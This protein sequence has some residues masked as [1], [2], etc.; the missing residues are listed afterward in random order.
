MEVAERDLGFGHPLCR[1]FLVP[2]RRLCRIALD[3][4]AG[5][6]HLRQ[7]VLRMAIAL[8]GGKTIPF[9]GGCPVALDPLA[10]VI[11]RTEL[12]LRAGITLLGRLPEPICRRRRIRERSRFH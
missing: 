4:V 8:L 10:L 7:I 11:E 9:G 6:Q 1:R 12:K 2:C 5:Q 3:P